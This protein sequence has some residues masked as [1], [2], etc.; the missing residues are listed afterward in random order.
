MFKYQCTTTKFTLVSII[1]L[2][3]VL[4]P[5]IVTINI[6][7]YYIDTYLPVFF[8]S[9]VHYIWFLV[10]T[11]KYGCS[12]SNTE[13]INFTIKIVQLIDISYQNY[14]VCSTGQEKQN[15]I[16]LKRFIL[17]YDIIGRTLRISQGARHTESLISWWPSQS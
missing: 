9:E 17:I 10:Q 1:Y 2:Y 13:K 14:P 11:S 15:C 6:T 3:F 4:V 7:N 12:R 16:N 8:I 5:K